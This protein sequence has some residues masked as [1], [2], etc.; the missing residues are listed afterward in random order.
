MPFKGWDGVPIEEYLQQH[1]IPHLATRGL[2]DD[3]IR[4]VAEDIEYRLA[5]VLCR[6]NDGYFRE[7]ILLLGEEEAAFWE[8][9]D[10]DLAV[11]SLVVVAIRNSLLEDLAST[12]EAARRLGLERAVLPDGEMP[13]LTREAIRFFGSV[14]LARECRKIAV[15]PP[16]YDVFGNL[17]TKYP[18]SWRAL[19]EL[20]SLSYGEV[21]Y[22]PVSARAPALQVGRPAELATGTM[23]GVRVLSGI[24]LEI[25]PELQRSLRLVR[26]G[27]Y[28]GLF[29]DCFKMITRNPQKLFRVMEFVLANERAVVTH[30]YYLRN[31]YVSRRSPL[32]RPAHTLEEARTKFH[33]TTGLLPCH[34]ETI[35]RFAPAR[36]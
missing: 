6:W 23:G 32:V 19:G 5:S 16:D 27:M 26:T 28:P 34:A 30:N 33:D 20:A 3:Q 22:P 13:L 8:P 2:D 10:V 11:R 9:E 4:R 29:S 18:M 14:D 15:P 1:L 25:E 24:A 35:A 21:S 31:G 7:P 17:P 12:T 36:L